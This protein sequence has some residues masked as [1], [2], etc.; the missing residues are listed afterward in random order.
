MEEKPK[1]KEKPKRRAFSRPFIGMSVILLLVFFAGFL[2]WIPFSCACS[3]P[4]PTGSV[5]ELYVTQ[6]DNSTHIAGSAT[7]AINDATSTQAAINTPSLPELF[8]TATALDIMFWATNATIEPTISIRS[9]QLTATA[10][11]LLWPA[12]T[13]E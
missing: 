12:A 4:A 2:L 9:V 13:P 11:D 1:R 7:A 8:L 3:P 6:Y 10:L 5:R